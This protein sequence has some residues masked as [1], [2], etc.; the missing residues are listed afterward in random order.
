LRLRYARSWAFLDVLDAIN[1]LQQSGIDRVVLIGWSL[2]GGL[3]MEAGRHPAVVGVGAIA[4]AR[5]IGAASRFQDKEMLIVSGT[6][7]ESVPMSTSLDI[8]AKSS[9]P[10]MLVAMKG[11]D[12]QLSN[13]NL[14]A[15]DLFAE[16]APRVLAKKSEEIQLETAQQEKVVVAAE[17]DKELAYTIGPGQDWTKI[18]G[19]CRAKNAPRLDV[20]V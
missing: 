12:H 8:F 4:P 1:H 13:T 18:I 7:D 14:E 16:W 19:T 11:D 5:G 3:A 6:E 9:V 2:G 10:R 15:V 20:T 17:E